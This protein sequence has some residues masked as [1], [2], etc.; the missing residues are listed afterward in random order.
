MRKIYN[1]ILCLSSIIIWILMLMS[2]R[3]EY[4]LNYELAIYA[5][6]LSLVSTVM[7]VILWFMKKR[8]IKE[9]FKITIAYLIFSSPISIF[10]FIELYGKLIGSFFKL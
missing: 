3:V 2:H 5:F 9:S 8:I 10:L 7:I 4:D 6:L 1:I